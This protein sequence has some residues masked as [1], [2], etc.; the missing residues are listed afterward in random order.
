M[1]RRDHS[2][3]PVATATRPELLKTLSCWFY[4]TELNPG[5]WRAGRRCACLNTE[6][7]NKISQLSFILSSGA[8]QVAVVRVKG[9]PAQQASELCPLFIICFPVPGR[10]HGAL[11]KHDKYVDQL[12]EE[13]FTSSFPWLCFCFLSLRCHVISVTL[14]LHLTDISRH[15][16][17]TVFAGFWSLV[18]H[19]VLR[20]CVMWI[21]ML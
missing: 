1:L 7:A 16:V 18:H 21:S 17:M 2:R 6:D 9:H 12:P 19:V 11:L 13:T 8:R 4:V 5:S 10:S 14:L 15:L 20:V 3:A